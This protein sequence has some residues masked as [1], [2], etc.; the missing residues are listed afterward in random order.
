MVPAQGVMMEDVSP[1]ITSEEAL[2]ELIGEPADL[3]RAKVSNRVNEL[4][5]R[6]IDLS[7]F[8]LALLVRCPG[9]FRL[10]AAQAGGA[11]T[12]YRDRHAPVPYW[13]PVER[14]GTRH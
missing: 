1:P 4:T 13:L 3:V 2:R 8:M 6:F 14:F 12:R 9:T 10:F 7:P 11:S 5:R